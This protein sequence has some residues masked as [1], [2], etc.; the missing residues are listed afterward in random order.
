MWLPP[1]KCLKKKRFLP[2]NRKR[3]GIFQ[4]IQASLS[5][6]LT[7]LSSFNSVEGK[8]CSIDLWMS[9]VSRMA[10]IRS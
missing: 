9:V 8:L 5:L 10:L 3:A 7:C 2:P 1:R 6:L 4:L